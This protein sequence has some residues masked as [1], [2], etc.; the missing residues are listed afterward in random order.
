MYAESRSLS[1]KPPIDCQIRTEQVLQAHTPFQD[2]V[3]QYADK[4]VLVIGGHDDD[5][6]CKDAGTNN[7][8]KAISE[9][10]SACD[11]A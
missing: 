9:A 2:F 5:Q 3:G 10:D 11:S 4:P 7:S 6:S 1:D 8:M